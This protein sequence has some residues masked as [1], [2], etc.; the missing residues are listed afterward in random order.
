[1]YKWAMKIKNT[2]HEFLGI[3]VTELSG[4]EFK[5]TQ[6]GLI[7]K[8]LKATDCLNVNPKPTPKRVERPFGTD[9]DGPPLEGKW[10]YD[11]VI[12]MLMYLASNS[13]PNIAFA[14]HQCTWF[15]HCTR[16]SHE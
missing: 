7:E 4:R 12:G 11:S 16:R 6:K 3:K 5:F 14:V 2:V 1:M 9:K 10:K 13:R 15:T 8:V